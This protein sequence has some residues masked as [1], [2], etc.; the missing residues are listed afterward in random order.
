VFSV[1][2]F[3]VWGSGLRGFGFGVEGSGVLGFG[4]WVQGLGFRGWGQTERDGRDVPPC[5][6]HAIAL[7]RSGCGVEGLG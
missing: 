4:F 3:R 7:Q 5:E 2:E 6:Y 1:Q